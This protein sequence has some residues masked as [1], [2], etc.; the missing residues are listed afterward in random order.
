MTNN[1]KENRIPVCI[2]VCTR[3]RPQMLQ[4]LLDSLAQVD[5]PESVVVSL[6]II[7]NDKEETCRALLAGM[8]LP[9]WERVDYFLEPRI[10]ISQAR[11][12]LLQ[13]AL[14]IEARAL[15]FIDD[16]EIVADSWLQELCHFAALHAWKAVIQGA[17]IATF[18]ASDRPYLF[19]F[20][21]RK[22]RHTGEVL[23]ACSSNNT[24]LPMAIISQCGLRFDEQ[25]GT[26]GGEDTVFFDSLRANGEAIFYCREAVVN[27]IIPASRMKVGWLAQR[28]L[29]VGLLLGSGRLYR[30]QKSLLRSLFY[31]FKSLLY[32]IQ[33]L[34]FIMLFK[35]E[36]VV[37]AWLKC[38]KSIG[39]FLGYFGVQ[40]NP[41]KVI[42]GR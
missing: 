1:D 28:K 7:E 22:L 39:V 24:L 18:E 37:N 31:L 15:I 40:I 35:R 17:V 19:P 36:S 29:R 23:T 16:D 25:L 41:Y 38:C 6:C 3:R 4:A 10:G 2:G 20:F 33:A 34:F 14:D 8:R 9:G 12:R 32:A 30:K 21:Q 5:I 42:D 13:H 27:E 11:N 26:Q